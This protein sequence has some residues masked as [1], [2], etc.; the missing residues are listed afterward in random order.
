MA[1]L[2]TR[3]F[4]PYFSARATIC[5]GYCYKNDITRSNLL[6]NKETRVICQGFT[7]K[8][9]TEHSRHAIQYGT[10]L[11][12]G[13]S[14]GKGGKTHLDRPVFNTVREAIEQTGANASI[15]FVPPKAASDAIIEAID[16][17]IGLV[18]C[19][20]D[21]IPQ[22]DMVKVKHKLIR[23]DKTRLIGPNCPGIIKPDECKI[24]IMPGHIHKR[25]KIGVVSRSGTLTYESV[26]Q[27]SAVGLGQSLCVGIGG[28]PFNGT[29]FVDC[30]D[31]FLKDE[32]TE[33]EENYCKFSCQPLVGKEF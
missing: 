3:N 10:N 32:E 5:R 16:A 27:T 30:I 13:T 28:D 25:G 9:G 22:L 6:I 18:V 1:K 12:G 11:V 29:N 7:G 31:V 15:I 2:I 19:I 26:W 17:A 21:G 33:G 20:T 4:V 14:P 24:G 23:Q 8:Q